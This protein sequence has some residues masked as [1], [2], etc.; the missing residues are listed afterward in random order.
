MTPAFNVLFL[1]T[2]N[3]ARSIMAEAILDK[4]GKGKF[5]AYSAGSDPATRADARG[6]RKAAGA[7]PRRLAAA[8][9]IL[10]RVHRAR[11]A[12]HGFRDRALRHA[13]RPD[14]PRFRRQGRHRL[15]GRCPTPPSSPARRRARGAAE[16]ALRHDPPRLEIFTNL[17][18]ATLDRMAVQ[19]A[20]RRDR[21]GDAGFRPEARRSRCASASTAW[22]ASAGSRCGRHWA[23]CSGRRTIRAPATGSTS[24]MST[25]SRAARRRPR[26][27][28]NSTACTAAGARRFERRR[29]ERDRRRRAAHRISAQ[30]PVP[31]DVPWGDLGCDIVLECTGKFLKPEQLQGY[32]DRGVRR[33][34]VAAP[35]KDAAALNI[36]VGVNDHL[37]DPREHRL[38][39]AA[40]CTTNCL[41]PVVK[42]VHEAHRHPPRPDHDH[43]RPDQHQCRGRRA[44]QG[45]A[46]RPLGHAVA[47]ADDDRQRHRHRADLSGAEGQ[48]QRPRRARAGAQRDPDRLRLRAGAANDGREEVNAL[49]RAAAARAARR[50]SRLRGAAAGLGR[51]QQRHPQL[52]RRRAEHAWSPTARC[53]RS[54]PGTTTRSAMPAAWSISPTSSSSGG[55]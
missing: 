38:L 31:G 20:P 44:A 25:R 1:C 48:A 23:R 24:C 34:I 33:V 40:S 52:D 7:R 12:A 11:R 26:I 16:R 19:G 5:R 53:S 36:V 3:S 49:F 27:C 45:F 22:A 9:Q 39:T 8:L 37:Y 13:R 2:H 15:P 10:E 54:M 35:V 4:I 6:A 43:P 47:A 29:R 32:F 21:R 41:A 51:L 18:F 28:S 42:V 14:L 30:Q 50:H 46:P 17:P 55:A